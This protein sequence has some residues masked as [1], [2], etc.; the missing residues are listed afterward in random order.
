MSNKNNKLLFDGFNFQTEYSSKSQKNI[1]SNNNSNTS[2]SDYMKT[3]SE[4]NITE[5]DD[6]SNLSNSQNNYTETNPS[7]DECE[8]AEFASE[9]DIIFQ[10]KV[11]EKIYSKYLGI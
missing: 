8:L 1:K 7:I 4:T 2:E 5:S 9:S 10:D 3:I 11:Q 6:S